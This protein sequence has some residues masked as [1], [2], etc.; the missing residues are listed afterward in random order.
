MKKITIKLFAFCLPLIV[1]LYLIPVDKR[2]IYAG[3]DTN[4]SDHLIKLY[5]RLHSNPR[6]VDIVF[7]GTSHTMNAIEDGQI[8]SL[9]S[10]SSKHVLNMGYC[11]FGLDLYYA[12]LQELIKAKNPKHII[13]EIR[14]EDDR[15]THP[16][17]AYVA[18]NKDVV[19]ASLLFNPDYLKENYN[20]IYYK[21][22]VLRKQFFEENNLPP[23]NTDN[24]GCLSFPDT[25]SSV[26][27][28]NAKSKWKNDSLSP[29]ETWFYMKFPR[30][31]YDKIGELCIE[32]NIKISFLY[33]PGY[34]EPYGR[35]SEIETYKK[36]GN[37]MIP[38]D[39]IFQNKNYWVD[40]NHLNKAGA[41]VLSA[42]VAT[43]TL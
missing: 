23:V 22:E 9:L 8:D 27:L 6:P 14:N 26:T 41:R 7:L 21:M 30:S 12:F 31:Y 32:N 19:T 15:Y 34:S 37:I 18:G 29:F 39:S 17:Y 20:H 11:Q 40:E 35:I 38:P 42:W 36:Y 33:I 5:D 2:R 3:L 1:L 13:I 43:Q 24:Y 28:E 25:V 16:V 4:C 10:D